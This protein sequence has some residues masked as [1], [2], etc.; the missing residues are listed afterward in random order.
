[1]PANGISFFFSNGLDL[2]T[3]K[4]Y[5]PPI[6]KLAGTV[7]LSLSECAMGAKCDIELLE[8]S[9]IL[10]IYTLFKLHLY[11]LATVSCFRYFWYSNIENLI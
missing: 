1:M 3:K 2:L 8:T 5:R 4:R 11:R 10:L 9:V 7:G 6:M